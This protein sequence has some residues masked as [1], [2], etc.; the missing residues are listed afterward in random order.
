[1]GGGSVH[2]LHSPPLHPFTDTATLKVS[3]ARCYS[4]LLLHASNVC[5]VGD[6]YRYTI[7]YTPQPDRAL[8][9]VALYLRIKNTA[10]LPLRAAYLHGPYTLYVSVRRKEFQPWPSK[11]PGSQAR[12][13]E[14]Q[15]EE[16]RG[17]IGE[18]GIPEFVFP[19]N[20]LA[21]SPTYPCNVL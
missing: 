3:T 15:S 14:L 5:K 9:P 12:E 21:P 8:P 1:M 6:I 13:E 4:M 19:Q 20:S 18:G 7:T 11:S 10:L 2:K 17:G 16:D